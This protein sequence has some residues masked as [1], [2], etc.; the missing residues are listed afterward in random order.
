MTA[1]LFVTN[2]VVVITTACLFLVTAY[3]FLPK[4]K[5]NLLM[6]PKP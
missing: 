2:E 4:L 6:M 5:Q 1:C 3:A